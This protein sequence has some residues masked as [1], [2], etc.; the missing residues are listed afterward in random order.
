MGLESLSLPVAVVSNTLDWI[1][2]EGSR[3]I[4]SVK[5]HT[6]TMDF[7]SSI[8]IGTPVMNY[9]FRVQIGHHML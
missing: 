6:F 7:N 3:L 8:G 5:Y 9:W 2:I 1:S 4:H